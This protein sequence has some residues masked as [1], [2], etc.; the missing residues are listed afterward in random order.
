MVQSYWSQQNSAFIVPDGN[1]FQFDVGGGKANQ[2]SEGSGQTLTIIGGQNGFFY[3]DSVTLNRSTGGVVTA[4]YDG[5]TV[6][7]D[8]GAISDVVIVE[9]GF[10]SLSVSNTG[11][12][13][14]SD[15]SINN[16]ADYGSHYWTVNGGSVGL[17]GWPLVSYTYGLPSIVSLTTGLGVNNVDVEGSPCVTVINDQ[18][19]TSGVLSFAQNGHSLASI[20]NFVDLIGGAVAVPQRPG[21]YL[22]RDGD[23]RRRLDHPAQHVPILRRRDRRGVLL[24]RVGRRHVQRD[25]EQ[26]DRQPLDREF[27]ALGQLADRLATRLPRGLL[28]HR[29]AANTLGSSS[30]SSDRRRPDLRLAA[31]WLNVW[32]TRTINYS[33][34]ASW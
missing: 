8:G 16:Q 10:G 15:T 9:P 19:N 27:D 32:S 1:S 26:Q 3:N 18:A 17:D 25:S 7:F 30:I 28:A 24:R 13:S 5:Q 34:M 11:N 33:D 14:G 21:R 23:L 12:W 6:Q 4:T 31:R 29:Q 20:K 22:V 2:F